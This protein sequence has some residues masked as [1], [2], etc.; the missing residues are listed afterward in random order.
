[1]FLKREPYE[2]GNNTHLKEYTIQ[3]GNIVESLM[4]K[5]SCVTTMLRNLGSE[6]NCRQWTTEDSDIPKSETWLVFSQSN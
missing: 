6:S 3:K 5:N 2:A 1:M 4:P